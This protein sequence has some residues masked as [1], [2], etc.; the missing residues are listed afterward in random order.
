MVDAVQ[1]DF[2][3]GRLDLAQEV[4]IAVDLRK[5]HKECCGRIEIPEGFQNPWC[6]ARV[7]AV[8]VREDE[9]PLN[10]GDPLD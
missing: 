1:C 5:Q 7:R 10:V 4:R 8:V 2:V 6:V 9:L 3:P